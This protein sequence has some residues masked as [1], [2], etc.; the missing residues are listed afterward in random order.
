MKMNR[1]LFIACLFYIGVANVL[2]QNNLPNIV[3]VL[4]DDMGIGDISAYNPDSKI[5]TPHIDQLAQQGI[6]FNDAHTAAS[7]CTPTRYGL[8]TGRY[9]WRTPLKERVVT[10][11]DGCLIPKERETVAS[12][13][14]RN[15]YNTALIGKWHIGLDW[16][17]KQGDSFTCDMR[18]I[19]AYEDQIDFSKPIKHGPNQLGF[20]YFYGIAASWDF[21]PYIFIENDKLVEKPVEKSGGWV[22]DIP[23]GKTAEDM[24]KDKGMPKQLW[25]EGY[26]GSL[27]PDDAIGVITDKSVEY[28]QNATKKDPFFLMVTYAAPH[29]PVVPSDDFKRGSECG[30]Y[31]DFCQELD[32][33]IGQIIKSLQ[34]QKLLENTMIVFTADNGA[35][36]KAIPMAIQKKYKH[37]PSYH[38][39]GYKARLDEG[40]HRVPFIVSWPNV[41]PEGTKNDELICLND[42]YATCA[43]LVNEKV[44]DHVAEDSYNI[45][46]VLKGEEMK[47][48][49]ERVVIHSDFTGYFGIRYKNWKLTYPKTKEPVLID[50]SN[51]LSEKN[52][53]SENHPEVVKDLTLMLTNAVKNGRTTPGKNQLNDGVDQWE[54]L[55][56]MK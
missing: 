37:S 40:G 46:P 4:V 34:Q 11:Y 14:K 10:G 7:I 50:L 47:E 36:L 32:H 31:G 12:L 29:T 16:T 6:M 3:Y 44:Q 8:M 18:D 23:E 28:I 20:D 53:L 19:P 43:A 51:D 21:P 45:L 48:N 33:G 1:I 35:S 54:Q 27:K 24:S 42:W 13:L 52:N 41:S 56:W 2:S 55:Y 26:S 9:C 17:P 5:Q 49:D 15:G 38:F 39:K 22:G 25:R 30:I